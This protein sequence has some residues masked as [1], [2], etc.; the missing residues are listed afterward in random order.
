MG[1]LKTRGPPPI[2]FRVD[3]QEA[4]AEEEELPIDTTPEVSYERA[5]QML[6]SQTYPPDGGISYTIRLHP[7]VTSKNTEIRGVIQDNSGTIY[8]RNF[9]GIET[10]LNIQSYTREMG[11]AI[12]EVWS[13]ILN[14]IEETYPEMVSKHRKRILEYVKTS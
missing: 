3:R 2:R 7:H 12:Y 5:C 9:P 11:Q 13:S 14:Y 10:R 8:L 1:R 4:F 6:E